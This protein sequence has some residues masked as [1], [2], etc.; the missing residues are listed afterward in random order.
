MIFQNAENIKVWIIK[1]QGNGRKD[2]K[3]TFLG[4]NLSEEEVLSVVELASF[5]KIQE[6]PSVNLES[7]IEFM[8]GQGGG[9]FIRKGRVGEWTN[10]MSDVMSRK[11]VTESKKGWKERGFLLLT[12]KLYCV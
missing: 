12:V 3:Q 9:K 7:V 8:E 5:N 10:H 11:F 2:V 6:N 4:K 1:P